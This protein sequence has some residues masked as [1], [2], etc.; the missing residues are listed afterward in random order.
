MTPVKKARSKKKIKMDDFPSLISVDVPL[1]E[2]GSA[3]YF[4]KFQKEWG[5]APYFVKFHIIRDCFAPKNGARKD[6]IP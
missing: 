5:S 3:P 2:W 1:K 4:V 6:E